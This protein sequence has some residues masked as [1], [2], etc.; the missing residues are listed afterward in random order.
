MYSLSIGGTLAPLFSFSWVFKAGALCVLTA[1]IPDATIAEAITIG[2]TV[3]LERN[4]VEI[5]NATLDRFVT[6]ENK[7]G[8]KLNISAS[9]EGAYTPLPYTYELEGVLYRQAGSSQGLWTYRLKEIDPILTPGSTV[10]YIDHTFLVES[11]TYEVRANYE[12]MVIAEAV[13]AP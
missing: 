9:V 8:A 12:Q 11:I 4:A 10:N 1:E 13:E 6:T 2:D 7:E 5:A 3:I